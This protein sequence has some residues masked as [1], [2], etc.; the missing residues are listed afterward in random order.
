[1]IIFKTTSPPMPGSARQN[2]NSLLTK[3]GRRDTLKFDKGSKA[4]H[5]PRVGAQLDQATS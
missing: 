2:L 3:S 1:M 5:Q 4:F